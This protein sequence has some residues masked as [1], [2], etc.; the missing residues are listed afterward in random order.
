MKEEVILT[1]VAQLE[2]I[3]LPDGLNFSEEDSMYLLY[4]RENIFVNTNN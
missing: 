1:H 2:W 3:D 4:E